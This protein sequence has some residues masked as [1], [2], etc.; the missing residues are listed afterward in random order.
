VIGVADAVVPLHHPPLQILPV[1]TPRFNVWVF[2]RWRWIPNGGVLIRFSLLLKDLFDD[3]QR[4]QLE[5]DMGPDTLLDVAHG[6]FTDDVSDFKGIGERHEDT[7]VLNGIGEVDRD[8][9]GLVSQHDLVALGGI[10]DLGRTV[11][12]T[13]PTGQVSGM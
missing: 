6:H 4:L 11:V 10:R 9:T 2:R 7:G 1:A 5:G 3:G 12:G 13:H 8:V